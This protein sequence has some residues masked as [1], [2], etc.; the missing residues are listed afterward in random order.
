M[1]KHINKSNYVLVCARPINFA[2]PQKTEICNAIHHNALIQNI[3]Y[4]YIIRVHYLLFFS[5]STRNSVVRSWTLWNPERSREPSWLLVEANR[6]CLVTL[7]NRL[8]SQMW[9]MICELLRKRYEGNK[10]KIMFA[11]FRRGG[12]RGAQKM[13][14][15]AIEDIILFCV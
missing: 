9:A 12:G 15:E 1:D 14:Y 7:W 5:R 4:P 2:Q 3:Q 10:V 11:L 13:V 8:C 6:T